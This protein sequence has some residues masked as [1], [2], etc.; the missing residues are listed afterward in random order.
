M[1]SAAVDYLYHTMYFWIILTAEMNKSSE[2]G[3]THLVVTPP[4]LV[5]TTLATDFL[6][7]SFDGLLILFSTLY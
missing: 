6:L 1:I 7:I 3:W 2:N 5:S 4:A